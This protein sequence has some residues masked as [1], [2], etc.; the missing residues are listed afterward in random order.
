MLGA[1]MIE[2]FP[3]QLPWYVI[4]P[5]I[6]LLVIGLFAIANKPLGASGAYMQVL[7]FW[8][9]RAGTEVW[10]CCYYVGI[11]AGAALVGVLRPGS[12]V[13][14]QYGLLGQA[15]PLPLLALV[16]F[17]AGIAMGYG[18]RWAGG[19]TSGHGLCGT[20][21]LSPASFAVTITFFA[22]AVGVTLV[23]HAL[24]GGLL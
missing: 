24:T 19:C 2:A 20:S 16:L 4:G 3:S 8:Q 23:L 15:L 18:A 13:G 6:G 12:S 21:Q 9:H 22:V 10:R 11:I 5:A 7:F 1:V 14:L 17:T